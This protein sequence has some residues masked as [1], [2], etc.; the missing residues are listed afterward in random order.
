MARR[1]ERSAYE[2]EFLHTYPILPSWMQKI[3]IGRVMDGV[4]HYDAEVKFVRD[5]IIFRAVQK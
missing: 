1:R 4:S 3:E 5:S 2:V